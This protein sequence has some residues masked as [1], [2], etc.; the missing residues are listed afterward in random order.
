MKWNR[1]FHQS[2][3]NW[4][5]FSKLGALSS[6]YFPKGDIYKEIAWIF[7]TQQTLGW[8]FIW[9]CTLI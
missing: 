8:N 2:K 4:G 9:G 1:D 5:Q 6:V 3:W 7:V